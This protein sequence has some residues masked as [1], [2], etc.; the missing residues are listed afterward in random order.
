MFAF[1]AEFW[2][3]LAFVAFLAALGGLG[4]HK[5]TLNLIDGRRDRI[6]AELDEAMR[7]KEEA[8]AL[9]SQYQRKQRE[10][11]QEA[12]EI[13]AGAQAE[14]ERMTGEAK[15][16]LEEFLARRTKMAE[17]KIVQAEA[18]ALADVRA[19]AAEAAATAAGKILAETVKDGVAHRLVVKGIDEM[20]RAF[21]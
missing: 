15:S 5:T 20:K 14:A 1:D 6:K 21:S 9:L 16:K 10:V 12:R 13:L 7:L 3:A 18:Q 19:A 2:V 17:D 8:R 4:V 11:E